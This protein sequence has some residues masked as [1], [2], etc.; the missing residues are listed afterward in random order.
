MAVWFDAGKVVRVVAQ[1]QARPTDAADVT[2]QMQA[3]WQ[4]DFDRLGALRRQEGSS[5]PVLQAYG[6]HDDKVRVRMLAQQTADGPRL[7][8]E[9]R[10]WPAAKR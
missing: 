10:Y 6:W 7:F 5:G 1:H 4:R 2:A 3:A 8:T 9:W